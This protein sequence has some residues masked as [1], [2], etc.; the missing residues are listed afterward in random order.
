MESLVKKEPGRTDWLRDLGVSL[1][2]V[3]RIFEDWAKARRL[4][5]TI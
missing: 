4:W 1:N 5:G 3:G 2:N